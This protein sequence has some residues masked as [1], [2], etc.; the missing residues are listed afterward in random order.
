MVN[1]PRHIRLLPSLNLPNQVVRRSHFWVIKEIDRILHIELTSKGL[2]PNYAG[3]T[4]QISLARIKKMD[5][6]LFRPRVLKFH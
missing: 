2:R 6:I 1:D 4:V 5:R 3:V